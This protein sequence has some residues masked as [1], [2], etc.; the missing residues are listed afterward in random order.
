MVMVNKDIS[1]ARKR[2]DKEKARL[3]EL[4]QAVERGFRELRASIP[5]VG[6]YHSKPCRDVENG[7]TQCILKYYCELKILENS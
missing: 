5:C 1:E 2:V 6:V 4:G 3:A 7:K